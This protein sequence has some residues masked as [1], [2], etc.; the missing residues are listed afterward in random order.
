MAC[1]STQKHSI[2]TPASRPRITNC[3]A[4]SAITLTLKHPDDQKALWDGLVNDGVSTTAT[5]EYPTSLELKLRGK[6]IDDV[7]GGNL[8]A[9]ARMG[10][11]YTEGVVKP[12]MTLQRF[13]P[14]RPVVQEDPQ[15]RRFPRERLQSVGR[16]GSQR[17]ARHNH[18]A[19]QGHRREGAAAGKSQ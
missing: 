10:I 11:I 6:E 16:M 1:L 12:G 4:A 13:S 8:G 17:M 9:E 7:I 3:R 2:I 15:T 5:D 19:W 18:P 14:D